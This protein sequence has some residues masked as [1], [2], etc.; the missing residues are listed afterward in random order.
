MT[1]FLKALSAAKRFWAYRKAQRDYGIVI[2]ITGTCNAKCYYCQVGQDNLNLVK[3]TKRLYFPVDDFRET[4]RYLKAHGLLTER[5]MLS[6]YCWNEPLLHPDFSRI[7]EICKEEKCL[8][9]F[10]TNASIRPRL[11][12]NFDAGFI[13]IISFSMPGFSQA[14]YDKIH[15]FDFEQIKSNIEWMVRSFRKH[16]FFGF[17]VIRFHVYQFNV[18]E[19]EPAEKWARSLGLCF[20]PYFAIIN[21]SKKL[22]QYIEANVPYD[23]L[24]HVSRDLDMGKYLYRNVQQRC[25]CSSMRNVLIDTDGRPFWCCQSDVG[26]GRLEDIKSLEQLL[27][28]RCNSEI[29]KKCLK[30]LKPDRFEHLGFFTEK[31]F[32]CR[33]SCSYVYQVLKTCFL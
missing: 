15:Q 31:K 30:I 16:G 3:S 33:V 14:S 27:K 10:S 4:V 5:E 9:S 29:C 11:S 22:W 24:M 13:A 28:M 12:S 17:F 19:I 18:H 6:L 25:E 1:Q 32:K 20:E 8:T 2:E 7:I 26:M 23:Y 21:D